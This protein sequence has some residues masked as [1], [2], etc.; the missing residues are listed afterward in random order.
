MVGKVLVWIDRL[1]YYILSRPVALLDLSWFTVLDTN[2]L[3]IEPKVKELWQA[4]MTLTGFSGFK[5]EHSATLFPILT[6]NRLNPSA[7]DFDWLTIDFAV[8]DIPQTV[9]DLFVENKVIV[10]KSIEVLKLG[11]KDKLNTAGLDFECIPGLGDLFEEVNI[12]LNPF[13]NIEKESQQ[14]KYYKENFGLVVSSYSF[15]VLILFVYSY[16]IYE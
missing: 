4:A 1:N 8:I 7:I 16:N 10:Q 6:K 3:V 12:S 11:V 15:S 14:Y 13:Q 5:Q 2:S 9:V